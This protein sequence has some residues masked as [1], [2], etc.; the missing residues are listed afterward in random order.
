MC[1]VLE[2]VLSQILHDELAPLAATVIRSQKKGR[3][4]NEGMKKIPVAKKFLVTLLLK[5]WKLVFER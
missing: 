3:N 1:S 5:E 4:P 2:P